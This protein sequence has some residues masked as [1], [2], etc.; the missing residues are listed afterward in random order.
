MDHSE[1]G[2]SGSKA[3]LGIS[4]TLSELRASGTKMIPHDKPERS[5]SIP[6]VWCDEPSL[7]CTSHCSILNY[8]AAIES[9][10]C[11]MAPVASQTNSSAA[12]PGGCCQTSR[13]CMDRGH[14][15]GALRSYTTLGGP[16]IIPN[17]PKRKELN[18]YCI[19]SQVTGYRSLFCT[20]PCL[21][22]SSQIRKAAYA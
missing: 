12:F 2:T 7:M 5:R 10:G 18:T 9:G 8:S 13:E 19:R 4:L 15:R 17:Y 22:K 16:L 3:G 20:P 6:S 21:V 1:E 14:P 11:E